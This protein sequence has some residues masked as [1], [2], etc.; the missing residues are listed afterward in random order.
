MK[1]TLF[2]LIVLS[3]IS[4][5]AKTIIVKQDGTG[6]YTTIQD[7][8]NASQDGDTILVWPGTYYENINFNGNNI[9]VGS[10][11]LT[12]GDDAYIDQTII[13][14]DKTGSCVR[15]DSFESD[16]ELCGFSLTNG[17]GTGNNTKNGGGIFLRYST[18]IIDR[19]E[20][21]ENEVISGGGGVYCLDATSFFSSLN[22]YDNH[23]YD[24]GGGI[25]IGGYSNVIFDSINPC[26]IYHNYAA[27][28]NDVL[29][30]TISN[31][32]FVVDTFTVF[33]PT[34]FHLYHSDENGF[35]IAL[36]Y[37]ILNQKINPVNADLHVSPYGDN[38]NSGLSPESPLK[39][40]NFALS[41]ILPDTNNPKTI[42]IA[43][44]CYS[45][46]NGNIYP[47][48]L[49]SYV[50][51]N[52]QERDSTILDAG[53]M[54]VLLRGDHF[55]RDY[56]IKHLTFQNGNGNI[57]FSNHFGACIIAY[58]DNLIFEDILFTN[59]WGNIASC[60]TF[61]QINN[62]VFKNVE[63]YRNFGHKAFRTGMLPEYPYHLKLINCYWHENAPI[64]DTTSTAGGAVSVL[65]NYTDPDTSACYLINCLI[66][67]N[68]SYYTP[69]HYLNMI[70]VVNG[71]Q[72]YIINSTIGNNYHANFYSGNIC[73]SDNAE[74][75]IYNSIMFGNS[76]PE[77][78]MTSANG[79]AELNI[80]NSLLA[81][82]QN[83]I[84]FLNS[85]NIVY[86]DPSN[87][88]NDPMWDTASMYP[89]SLSLGSPCIDAGTLELPAGFEL[90]E[91]DLAGNPRV[92][93]NGVDMGAYEHG[94]WVGIDYY[95]SK[96]KTQDPELIEASPNPFAYGTHIKYEAPKGGHV[97]IAVF[98]LKGQKIRTL[99]DSYQAPGVGEF[100]WDG[101]TDG[102]WELSP[103][104]YLINI[105][106]NGKNKGNLKLIRN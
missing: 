94:P 69:P 17:S 10:L 64:G 80:Y 31:V 106:I 15:I 90:P 77:I 68:H 47:L 11:A 104:T 32:D 8:I 5:H 92:W 85:G 49:R 23:S 3:T 36:N 53:N 78:Y 91:C 24:K 105:I 55:T 99:I 21:F 83:G 63:F 93:G 75:H 18:S 65:S 87:I 84:A 82:G 71:A 33:N 73:V 54:G 66:S 79:N 12:T 100:Y 62:G 102:G 51:I 35:P 76:P 52:G 41:K 38:N 60:G 88:D 30:G 34:P 6:D 81:G 26:N 42:Y 29:I 44:G 37:T 22:I 39:T 48:S 16:A 14:G 50:H 4:I 56:S 9:M 19:C 67:D 89:F 72:A 2:L 40:V 13:N 58:N 59:N 45:P 46:T 57:Y 20:I 43:N 27:R 61:N 86:Y 101:T 28:G 74:L 97:K 7:G 70:A 1:N 103:G 25:V 98:N 95:N 96:F